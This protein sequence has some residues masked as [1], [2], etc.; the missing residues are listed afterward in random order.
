[1]PRPYES[2]K[3]FIESTG[4]EELLDLYSDFLKTVNDDL[5]M[6]KLKE[7][8]YDMTSIPKNSIDKPMGPGGKKP[9]AK[10]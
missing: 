3:D 7:L 4:N 10:V 2:F 6:K 5:M 8:G 1:M 9:K